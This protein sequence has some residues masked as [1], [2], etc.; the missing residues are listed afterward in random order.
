M[1]LRYLPADWQ[2]LP[3]GIEPLCVELW[4][5]PT[6][7]ERIV[8]EKLPSNLRFHSHVITERD[9][10]GPVCSVLRL[11]NSHYAGQILEFLV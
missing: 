11:T 1:K 2:M 5:Q 4:A 3:D 9:S 6:K 7:L 8:N 10:F